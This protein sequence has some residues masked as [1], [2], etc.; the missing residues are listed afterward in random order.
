MCTTGS[1]HYVNEK[2]KT[3]HILS[4][5]NLVQKL[6]FM[7]KKDALVVIT[8]NL[9][10]SLHTVTLEGDAKELMKVRVTQQSR[11]AIFNLLLGFFKIIVSFTQK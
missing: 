1:V 5:H 2:G 4:A 8:E 11:A 9:L 10:L 6:L 7:E 3:S